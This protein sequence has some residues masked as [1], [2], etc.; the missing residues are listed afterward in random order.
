MDASEIRFKNYIKLRARFRE[1]PEE[2]LLPERGSLG[3]FATFIEVSE[4]YLSHVNNRRK[5]VGNKTAKKLEKAFELPHGWVDND[6]DRLLESDSCQAEKG[7]V[8]I[9]MKLYKESPIE[10]QALLLRYMAERSTK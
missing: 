9:A 7:F 10:M 8:A 4:A 1:R 6:H 5:P 3:R 2:V